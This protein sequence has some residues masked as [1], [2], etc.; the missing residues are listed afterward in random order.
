MSAPSDLQ[1]DPV[2]RQALQTK[3]D[4]KTKPVG[5]LGCL[6]ELALRLG[7]LQG[8]LEPRVRQPKA[9][10]FAGDH[11][12]AR[13]GLSAFPQEVTAQMVENFLGGGAAICVLCRQFGVELEVVDAGVARDLAPRP[14]LRLGKPAAG[15]RDYLVEP[16]MDAGQL[17]A[18]LALGKQS[19]EAAIQGGS[20]VLVLG[21]MGIGNT[22]SA[23]L[24][25]ACLL[26]APLELLVGRGTG[27]DDA[28]LAR[29]QALLARALARGGR[30]SDPK[31]VLAQYG[32]FEIAALVGAIRAAARARI[33]AV[34]DGFIVGAAALAA[35]RLDPGVLDACLFA[36]RSAEP[37][38]KLQL[39]GLGVRPL[40][41]LDLRLGEGSGAVLAIPLLRAAAAILGEMASFEQAGVSDKL[42]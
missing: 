4:R 30:P 18:A 41:E 2:L 40:L 20:N 26:P 37:G 10:I 42:S 1:A 21:E 33:L 38:H 29:K 31:E 16:A 23:A 9:L 39:E 19:A 8:S 14:G 3:L 6:E 34:L 35:A 5:S 36:H 13:A 7:L 15:T 27:L 25:S 24:L 11:G 32:G 12:A 17:E 22:A 28:G